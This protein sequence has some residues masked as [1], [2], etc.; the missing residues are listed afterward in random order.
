[1]SGRTEGLKLRCHSEHVAE[2]WAIHAAMMRPAPRQR[3]LEALHKLRRLT[4]GRED[5][6]R[7]ETPGAAEAEIHTWV[8]RLEVYPADVAIS[9]LADWPDRSKYWPSWAEIRELIDVA[10]SFRNCLKHELLK[11]GTAPVPEKVEPETDEHRAAVVERLWTEG[12][13]RTV[14][15]QPSPQAER[16]NAQAA[17]ARLEAEAPGYRAVVSDDLRKVVEGWKA[18]KKIPAPRERRG[19]EHRERSDQDRSDDVPTF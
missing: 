12:A 17:L 9:V 6:H 18:D 15:P 7:D 4:V 3:L 10:M 16:E 14:S 5:A 13:R 8:E 1:M 11:L 2:A 19:D